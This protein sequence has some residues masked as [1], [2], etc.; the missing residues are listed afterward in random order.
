MAPLCGCEGTSR[1]ILANTVWKV[2]KPCPIRKAASSPCSSGNL[3]QALFENSTLPENAQPLVG[4]SKFHGPLCFGRRRKFRRN[5]ATEKLPCGVPSYR[6]IAAAVQR[7]EKAIERVQIFV[8]IF[9][10]L[11]RRANLTRG[12]AA[13][14]VP[15]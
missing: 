9:G 7:Y 12:Y 2:P 11:E 4:E 14:M 15:V 6:T 10:N 1:R 5:I 8:C 13:E 3:A